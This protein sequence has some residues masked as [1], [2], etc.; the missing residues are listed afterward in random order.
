MI[1]FFTVYC[2][3]EGCPWGWVVLTDPG[4]LEV[5]SSGFISVVRILFTIGLVLMVGVG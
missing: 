1:V 2:F 3:V 4:L 5:Q